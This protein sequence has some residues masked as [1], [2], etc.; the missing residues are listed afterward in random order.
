MNIG[1]AIATIRQVKSISQTKIANQLDI[2]VSTL[3]LLENGK[4]KF[5]ANR[6][7]QLASALE[8]PVMFIIVSSLTPEERAELPHHI[9][10][11]LDNWRMGIW[12]QMEE[13]HANETDK[14]NVDNV[15]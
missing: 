13:S 1:S 12:A 10:A 5:P 6:L 9:M 15:A 3:S 8:V 2:S 14:L 11:Q 4:R 7:N